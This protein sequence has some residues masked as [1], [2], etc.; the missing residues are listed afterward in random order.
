[1]LKLSQ[2]IGFDWDNGNIN[3]N[4]EK[5]KIKIGKCEQIFFNKP[6][7]INLDEKHS[8]IE[9]RLYALGKTTDNKLLFVIFTIRKNKI[10]II[11][12]RKMNS[13]EKKIYEQEY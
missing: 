6:L 4:W 8:Q 7:I 11:S 5:H 12:A 1:M 2:I 3:K 9:E 10:R 13:A